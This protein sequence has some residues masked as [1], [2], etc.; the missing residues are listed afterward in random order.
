V[1]PPRPSEI[2]QSL[3]PPPAS[4]L[5]REDRTLVWREQAPDGLPTVAKLYRKRGPV[6]ELRSRLFRFRVEREFLRLAHLARWGVPVTI[7]LAWGHGW[8]RRDGFHELLLMK[9]VPAA[10]PLD[11]WLRE[12][13]ERGG[14]GGQFDI[15]SLV[16]T[17]RRM[18]ESGLCHQTLYAAN[19]LVR[20]EPAGD[21]AL[22][23]SDIPRS[24]VF[25][26]SLVGT[27]LALWDLL[28]L[29]YT[30]AEAG[31]FPEDE[32]VETYGREA[33]TSTDLRWMEVRLGA[34]PKTKRLRLRRDL[35]ARLRWAAAW[36]VLGWKRRRP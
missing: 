3:V 13:R 19:V 10:K 15:R 8:S 29:Q 16:C 30:L 11:E 32:L 26:H 35:V 34:D 2:V 24:W 1:T 5:K 12:L 25:P 6:T 7:P 20:T 23:L 18:H 36:V 17:V 31:C 22:V 27:R 9:E 33:F 21:V 4:V 28:D 14:G